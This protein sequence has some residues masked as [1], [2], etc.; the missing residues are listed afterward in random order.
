MAPVDAPGSASRPSAG[1]GWRWAL[2]AAVLAGVAV[3][4]AL[5]AY[6][7]AH[8]GDGAALYTLWFGTMVEAKAW[9]ATGAVALLAV[10]LVT[11]L[12]MYGRLPGVRG[13]PPWVA[14][15][16]RWSG[17]AAF[18]LTLPVAFACVWSLGLEDSPTR[19]LVH[20]AAGCLLFGAFTVKMLALRVR[21]LPGWVLPLLGGTV[22]ALLALAWTTSALWWFARGTP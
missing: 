15:T 6:A 16:H 7:D 13:A 21:S 18:G 19:V 9:L 2:A 11:A 5:A 12:A 3:S 4:G 1:A 10:Q 20:S 17:V 14:W 22:L 8:P